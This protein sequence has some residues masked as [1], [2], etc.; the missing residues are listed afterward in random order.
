MSYTAYGGGKRKTA[1][2]AAPYARAIPRFSQNEMDLFNTGVLLRANATPD[3]LIQ[4]Q[5]LTK[6]EIT[7]IKIRD[8]QNEIADNASKITR[9]KENLQMIYQNN[10]DLD[11]AKYRNKIASLLEKNAK[12]LEKMKKLKEKAEVQG[13]IYKQFSEIS[14]NVGKVNPLEG[15]KKAPEIKMTPLTEDELSYVPPQ[16][17]ARYQGTGYGL[18]VDSDL[19][20]MGGARRR[21]RR[22]PARRAPVRRRRV[23][24]RR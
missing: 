3:S 6:L 13:L 8:L 19:T 16:Y 9:A 20:G 17:M 1:R 15:S 2:K 12:N 22:A 14:A 18:G 21:K 24:R 4:R 23:A 10:L 11:P 7:N 5:P